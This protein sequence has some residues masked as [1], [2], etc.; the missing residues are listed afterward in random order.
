M[1]IYLNKYKFSV[2]VASVIVLLS[3]IPSSSLP[4][5]SL[6]SISFI[7]KIVHFGMYGFFSL[8][9]LLEMRRREPCHLRHLLLLMS[10]FFMSF[11]IEVLQATVVASRS[12]E[13]L[14]L[15]ANLF[16]LTAGYGTYRFILL[17]RS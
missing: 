15:L 11:V 17:I 3:L 16:G 14:D 8:V 1:F 9:A 2:F 6:F 10:F 13:W 7:D 4:D 12:A 5:S